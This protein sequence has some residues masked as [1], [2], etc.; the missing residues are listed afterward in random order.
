MTG[1]LSYGDDNFF[2][3]TLS[4][5]MKSAKKMP[6]EMELLE[7]DIA[8]LGFK[9]LE[10]V[11][12]FS[13]NN[14]LL[15]QG[16]ANSDYFHCGNYISKLIVRSAEAPFE[17][18]Y[19]IDYLAQI[20][21]ERDY[22]GFQQAGDL[23]FLLCSMFTKRCDRRMMRYRDYVQIGK[24]M[25]SNFY[26]K[27]NKKIAYLMSQYYQEMAEVTKYAINTLTK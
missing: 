6:K 23:C 4:E 22:Y 11:I 14:T 13:I 20:R 27:S 16:C 8:F 3:K 12:L 5:I 9:E 25:Y 24:V 18:L 19:A 2:A 7:E 15:E 17:S 1:H 21:D 10:K 26:S